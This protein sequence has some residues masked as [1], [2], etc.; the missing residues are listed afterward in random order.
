MGLFHTH[1]LFHAIV[2]MISVPLP[3]EALA[4]EAN[5][6]IYF[7]STRE[8]YRIVRDFTPTFIGQVRIVSF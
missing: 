4:L 1:I 5:N 2:L 3:I 7:T 8:F 6:I